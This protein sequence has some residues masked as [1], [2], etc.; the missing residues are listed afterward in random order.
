MGRLGLG[1]A[2]LW[3]RH[4]AVSSM[5][6][7][8]IVSCYG[9]GWLGKPACCCC[10]GAV[11]GWVCLMRLAASQVSHLHAAC[12][13][14]SSYLL[15]GHPHLS[16]Y[17]QT[18][19]FLRLPGDFPSRADAL[20]HACLPIRLPICLP[21]L[22][23]VYLSARLSLAC[24]PQGDAYAAAAAAVGTDFRQWREAE[25][26]AFLDQRGEDYDDCAD[27]EALVSGGMG[28]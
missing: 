12:L 7:A 15:P 26:R 9:L 27:L 13:P 6:K 25:I 20:P 3:Q 19:G 4:T 17:A 21:I 1:V 23:S 22:L 24:L 11:A 18:V 16:L 10:C 2:D 8:C 5:H 28:G 14:F